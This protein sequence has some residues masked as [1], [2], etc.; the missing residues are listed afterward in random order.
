MKNIDLAKS[1]KESDSDFLKKFPDFFVRWL[2]RVI[3][4]QEMNDIL[5]RYKNCKGAD[6][7]R[8]I[9]KEYNLT[10][11]VEGIENLPEKRKCF[12]AANHPF[13]V[14]DGL[15][16]TKTVLEK[17]GDLR[18][19]GNESFQYVPNLRPYLALVN[20]YGMSPRKY[21]AELEKVYQSD[22]A[23]THFPSG[24][25]SRRYNGKV[26]DQA[27]HK[28]FISRA[29]SCQRDIVPFYFHGGNSNLFYG[30]HL[31]RRIFGI[32]LTIELALL[33]RELFLKQNKT[34]RFTIG[35]PIPWQKFDS[36]H[37]HFEWAQKVRAHVYEMA[38]PGGS[39]IYFE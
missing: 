13:G 39:E 37:T 9:V 3:K 7:H 21:V 17:Y 15:I 1:I 30:I 35:K 6:F 34:V 27:W 12:F 20:P 8:A 2:E 14:V 31:L 38:A 11:E 10:L 32:K 33:P 23:I 5:E 16:L 25:V 18:A 19:I 36:T 22:V 26:L 29:I 24:S 28:S 4:Q